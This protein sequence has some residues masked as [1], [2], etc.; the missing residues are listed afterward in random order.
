MD[1]H[2]LGLF[3]SLVSDRLS[4]MAAVPKALFGDVRLYNSEL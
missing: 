4:L 2:I 1:I 3:L